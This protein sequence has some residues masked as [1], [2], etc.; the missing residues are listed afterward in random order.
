MV[1]VALANE[2]YSAREIAKKISCNQSVVSGVLKLERESS[3]VQKR[4]LLE[5]KRVTTKSQ[6]QYLNRMSLNNCRADVPD[7][8]VQFENACGVSLS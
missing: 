3:E 4:A 1:A 8:K 7:L 5:R 6:D 2:G